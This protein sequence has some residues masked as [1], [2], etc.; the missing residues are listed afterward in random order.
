[1]GTILEENIYSYSKV[2]TIFKV[3]VLFDVLKPLKPGFYIG[4]K[5]QRI[6]WVDFRFE[7]ISMF[8]FNCDFIGHNE[9]LYKFKN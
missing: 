6:N 2:T 5:K 4:N 7:K 9:E 8:C 3:K 1:M